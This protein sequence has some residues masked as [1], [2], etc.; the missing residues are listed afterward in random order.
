MTKLFYKEE[1]G[2]K[3]CPEVTLTKITS[4]TN[5]KWDSHCKI[6]GDNCQ[7]EDFKGEGLKELQEQAKQCKDNN[8]FGLPEQG[9]R[10]RKW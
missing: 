5:I 9:Q 1:Y 10:G 7:S 4:G 6:S 3:V 8:G 2:S